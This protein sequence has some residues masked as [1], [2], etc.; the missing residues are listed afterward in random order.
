MDIGRAFTFVTED[1]DW[2]KKVLLG[3]LISFIPLVGQ[4][5]MMGYA[6]EVLSNILK[7]R[8]LPLPEITEDVGGKIVKGVLLWVILLVYALPLILIAGCSSG[9]AV[10]FPQV[11]KDADVAGMLSMVWSGCFGCLT[12]IYAILMALLAPFLWAIYADTGQF[13]DA[14]KL[15]EIFAMIKATIGQTIIVALI[16]ALAMSVAISV[17]VLICGVGQAFT[18]FYVLLV[19]SFLYASLYRQAKA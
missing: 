12:L 7:G 17:G 15:G 6:L 13:G 3:G 9:G 2:V 19:N 14:F 5:Y 11:T 16:S 18:T 4:L 8:E 10:L 1:R